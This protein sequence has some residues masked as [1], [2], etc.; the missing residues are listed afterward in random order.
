MNKQILKTWFIAIFSITVLWSLCNLGFA[1]ASK[2]FETN[3][4]IYNCFI[5]IGASFS[6]L[7]YAGKGDLG[8]ETMRSLD[9]WAYGV[10]LI[11]TYII[12]Y[13]LVKHTT[14]TE[15]ALIQCF[16]VVACSVA[17]WFFLNRKITLYQS[18]GMLLISIGT[19][20][21]C[22]GV[23]QESKAIVISFTFLF[24]FLQ[25][26]RSIAAELHKT[27]AY[28][29]KRDNGK[30]KIRV[31]GY[32]M[33]IVSM[34]FLLFML[35]F[36]SIEFL[37]GSKI[38][39][40]IPP[41]NEFANPANIFIG[42]IVGAL[43]MGPIRVIEFTSVNKLKSENYLALGTIAPFSTLFWEWLTSPI[44]GLSLKDLTANDFMA[45]IIV[46]IGGLM[47]ALS[48][49]KRQVTNDHDEFVIYSL[50]DMQA[51]E[52]SKD[53]LEKAV[54][55][56]NRNI[57]LAS[58]ELS[59]PESVITTVLAKNNLALKKDILKKVER[60]YRKD[61]A[62]KD[63]LT[64]LLNRAGL[65]QKLTRLV[66]RQKEFVVFYID[67]NKFKPI[68]DNHG[69]HAGDEALQIISSRLVKFNKNCKLVS[70]VGGDE[71][72]VIL[73]NPNKFNLSVVLKELHEEI[74]RFF[75][76]DTVDIVASVTASIGY[77]R[78]SDHKKDNIEELIKKADAMMLKF[79]A[80]DSER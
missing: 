1:L 32:I 6:L 64:G 54:T 41:I 7:L 53:V 36:T 3:S 30:D 74:A 16:G 34:M 48:K 63:S 26:A 35:L 19:I 75:T 56:F 68:N 24:A 27:H 43:I 11:L 17:G 29:I 15:G 76:L 40:F 9:T 62:T 47:I 10:L 37:T 55:H 2:V 33:F 72:T 45:G 12:I 20:I 61:I 31:V 60:T 59:L 46:V 28:A 71:F 52:D 67:L 80:V 65:M 49:A 38:I 77:V 58:A 73:E 14:A 8:V 21:I 70:R 79:K 78:S 5:F 22:L 69:H 66:H 57:K 50:N 18:C 13:G 51:V 4:I 25:S 42:L 44:T 23:P 39:E